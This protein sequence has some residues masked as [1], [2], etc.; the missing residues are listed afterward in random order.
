MRFLPALL[1]V[2]QISAC[3]APPSGEA[4]EL[5]GSS[6]TV[7]RIVLEDGGLERGDGAQQVTFGDDGSIAISSCNDCSGRFVIEDDA[8]SFS[9]VLACT[10]RACPTGTLE[11]ERLLGD[12]TQIS[13]DGD[14][15]VLQPEGSET[16]ILL[17]RSV[18]PA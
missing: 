17:S 15:L 8:L 7:E 2:L 4:A 5:P 10:K 13:R 3:S 18:V 16:R 1:V 6:W 14:F 9:N 12:E 11:L